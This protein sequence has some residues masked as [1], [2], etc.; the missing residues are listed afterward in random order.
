MKKAAR[1]GQPSDKALERLLLAD[2][3]EDLKGQH[4]SCCRSLRIN[5]QSGK[6]GE[7]KLIKLDSG[8][9]RKEVAAETIKLRDGQLCLC[10]LRWDNAELSKICD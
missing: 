3:V 8:C 2:H 9:Y 4:L 6:V 5:S 1:Y 10:R 7:G